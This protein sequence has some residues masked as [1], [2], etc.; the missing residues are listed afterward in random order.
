[1]PDLPSTTSLTTAL[2]KAQVADE[3]CARQRLL[4]LRQSRMDIDLLSARLDHAPLLSI[5]SIQ[6]HHHHH[7]QHHHHQQQQHQQI[8][9]ESAGAQGMQLLPANIQQSQKKAQ[10]AIHQVIANGT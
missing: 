10:D 7:H 4:S 8:Q 2:H 9:L 5:P 3:M 6:H 1:M